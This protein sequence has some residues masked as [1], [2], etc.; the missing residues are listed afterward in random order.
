MHL[1][2]L[3]RIAVG[4]GYSARFGEACFHLVDDHSGMMKFRQHQNQSIDGFCACSCHYS[5]NLKNL[6]KFKIL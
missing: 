5:I 6:I 1:R 3:C 4:V 2:I